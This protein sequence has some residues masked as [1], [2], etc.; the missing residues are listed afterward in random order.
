VP[1]LGASY[2]SQRTPW[3][4]TLGRRSIWRL[5]FVLRP[6]DRK[7]MRESFEKVGEFYVD[8]AGNTY[9]CVEEFV[10]ANQLPDSPALRVAII[11]IAHETFPGIRI[12]EEW[13]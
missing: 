6:F 9:F 5:V 3:L 7:L 10:R 4:L 8:H 11:E 2:W 1:T 12:L 13:N